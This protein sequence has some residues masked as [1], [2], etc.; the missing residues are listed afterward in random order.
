MLKPAQKMSE[1]EMEVMRVIWAFEGPVTSAQVQ[2]SLSGRGW[3]PTT[4]LTFLSRLTEKGFLRTEKQ[5]KSNR[6]IPLL[7]EAEY[8]KWETQTFLKEVHGGSLQSFFAALSG[9]EKLSGSDIEE[10]KQWLLK[11]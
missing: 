8:K 5:G 11:Q 6:Y 9:G 2:E 4:V 3:K 10:L 7:S 1:S